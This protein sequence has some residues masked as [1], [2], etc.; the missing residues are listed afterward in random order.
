MPSKRSEFIGGD[1]RRSATVV[2]PRLDCT[3]TTKAAQDAFFKHVEANTQPNPIG[4]GRVYEGMAL[5][6]V[7]ALLGAIW[8]DEVRALIKQQGY[9]TRTMKMLCVAADQYGVI[10]RLSPVRIGHEGLTDNALRKWYKRFGFKDYAGGYMQRD[11]G[12]PPHT[13]IL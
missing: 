3:T 1:Q 5:V 11:P 2:I 10:M 8:V 4:K 7:S 9:G 13:V 6:D 12:L